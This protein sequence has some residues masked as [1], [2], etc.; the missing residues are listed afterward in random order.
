MV[1]SINNNNIDHNTNISHTHIDKW[2]LCVNPLSSPVHPCLLF[3]LDLDQTYCSNIA[4]SI[5]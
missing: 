2:L 4:M 1:K 3:T 5:D